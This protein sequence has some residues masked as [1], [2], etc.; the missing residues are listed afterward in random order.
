MPEPRAL[1][2]I[3]S[4]IH[5]AFIRHNTRALTQINVFRYSHHVIPLRKF[6][7]NISSSNRYTY[8]KILENFTKEQEK[9]QIID[10]S[11]VELKKGSNPLYRSAACSSAYQARAQ[12]YY[13]TADAKRSALVTTVSSKR[14]MATTSWVDHAPSNVK[15]YLLLARMDKPAGTWLLLWP[16]WWSIAIAAPAGA[17]PNFVLMTQFAVGAFVMRG[18]GCTINDLWDRDI[19]AQVI[20]RINRVNRTL[21]NAL[22][23]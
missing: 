20:R 6:V 5:S 2:S 12:V 13:L 9:I 1:R 22:S 18:A 21:S 23:R 8:P 7:A 3:V 4:R 14:S 11:S 15:P 19:D 17:L 16:C 10:K